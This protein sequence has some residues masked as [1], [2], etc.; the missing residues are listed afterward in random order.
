M[1]GA[2]NWGDVEFNL[3]GVQVSRLTYEP[4]A[5]ILNSPELYLYDTSILSVL[6]IFPR[7]KGLCCSNH[8]QAWYQNIQI[9]FRRT[10]RLMNAPGILTTSPYYLYPN[11]ERTKSGNVPKIVLS[12]PFPI[13][14]KIKVSHSPM[15]SC[16]HLIFWHIF[17][18]ILSR[19]RVKQFKSCK[20]RPNHC[21]ANGWIHWTRG[22][23]K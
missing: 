16:F 20:P 15:I 10:L 6:L 14:T 22:R 9:L 17:F 3:L 1:C 7:I 23:S 5:V 2:V 8:R 18:S 11:H 21:H 12:S 13:L 19:L 4:T